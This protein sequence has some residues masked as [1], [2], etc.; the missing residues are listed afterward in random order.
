[1]LAS[2][3]ALIA[4][5][6]VNG[7]GVFSGNIKISE[8]FFG[9]NILTSLGSLAIFM[10][11]R[12]F[13]SLPKKMKIV[14][15]LLTIAYL[16]FQIFSGIRWTVILLILMCLSLINVDRKRFLYFVILSAAIVG[17]FVFANYFRRG[18][19]EIE[20]YYIQP[21]LYNGSIDLFFSTEIF[22]Y[23]G[24]SQRLIE[25]YLTSMSPGYAHGT[26]TLY[27]FFKWFVSI[28][29]PENIWV[30]GYNALNIIGYLWGDFGHLWPLALFVWSLAIALVYRI[31][32]FNKKNSLIQFLWSIGFMSVVLSFFCYMQHYT[33]WLTLFP[34]T[35][36][37]IRFISSLFKNQYGYLSSSRKQ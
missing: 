29:L 7:L 12:S 8:P 3:F 28:Q 24:M 14:M 4:N 33:Y 25:S 21:G 32:T 36:I 13:K 19:D 6:L 9:Y 5:T 31:Y 17:I 37:L 20:K 16:F 23:F 11:F 15:I 34:L 10:L 2:V 27:S 35:V 18:A 1:M 30:N 26:F 22:R